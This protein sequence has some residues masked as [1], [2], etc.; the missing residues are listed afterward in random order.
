MTSETSAPA[1]V[2]SQ[3]PAGAPPTTPVQ[4]PP[5]EDDLGLDSESLGTRQEDAHI[6]ISC[7]GGC[8]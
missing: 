4:P 8:E 7:A 6:F 2:A 3:T 1:S 5:M